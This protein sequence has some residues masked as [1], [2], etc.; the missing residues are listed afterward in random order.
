MSQPPVEVAAQLL[1]NQQKESHPAPMARCTWKFKTVAETTLT[2]AA[3]YWHWQVVLADKSVRLSTRLFGT[4]GECV[5]DAR[6]NGFTG[7]VD[8]LDGRIVSTSNGRQ[9]EITE[10]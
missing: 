4:L 8:S 9:L 1:K 6:R 3:H 5:Q 7:I 2:S 10:D